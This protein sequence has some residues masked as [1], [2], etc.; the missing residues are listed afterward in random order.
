M[1]NSPAYNPANLIWDDTAKM[2]SLDI[3]EARYD[4]CTYNG[5]RGL[6]EKVKYAKEK[7]LG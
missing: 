3:S 7:G 4:F 5:E 6:Q 1:L 2:Y